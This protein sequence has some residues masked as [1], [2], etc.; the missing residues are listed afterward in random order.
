MEP[1]PQEHSISQDTSDASSSAIEGSCESRRSG[2]EKA[3]P[4]VA[5]AHRPFADAATCAPALV[6]ASVRSTR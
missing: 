6:H 3:I 5:N 1:L 2:V 4:Y